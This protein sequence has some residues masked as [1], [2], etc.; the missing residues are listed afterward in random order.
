MMCVVALM[1]LR[2]GV[3]HVIPNALH[4]NYRIPLLRTPIEQ[5]S[6]YDRRLRANVQRTIRI[7]SKSRPSPTIYFFDDSECEALIREVADAETAS[8]FANEAE[9]MYRSDM[10]RAAGLYR[11]G[12]LYFDNDM[13]TL[14]SAWDRLRP[15]V[16]FVTVHDVEERYFFQSFMG[17]TPRSELMLTY[18]FGLRAHYRG[19]HVLNGLLGVQAL[20]IAYTAHA[21]DPRL[22]EVQLWNEVD[23]SKTHHRRDRLWGWEKLCDYLVVDDEDR[24]VF[25]SRMVGSPKC[26]DLLDVNRTLV[27]NLSI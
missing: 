5:L 9:G 17:S 12:G 25:W 26:R 7:H 10:C 3:G 11:Y 22:R 18:L 8:Y 15:T 27:T 19:T 2:I 14:V 24:P 1:M 20:R 4:F 16:Q 23:N 13:Q 6:K 21:H